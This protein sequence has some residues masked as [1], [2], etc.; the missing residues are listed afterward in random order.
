MEKIKD[1]AK[2]Y[3]ITLKL[4]SNGYYI[5]RISLGIGVGASP[6]LEKSGTTAENALLN[7]LNELILYIDV[8]FSSG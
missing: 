8:S 4:K 3:E 5:A 6:R 2:K 1:R 7:L